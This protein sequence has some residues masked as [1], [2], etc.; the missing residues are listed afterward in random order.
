MNLNHFAEFELENTSLFRGVEPETIQDL[1][2]AALAE[3]EL[4]HYVK[5]Y[6]KK[7]QSNEFLSSEKSRVDGVDDIFEQLLG[8]P[9]RAGSE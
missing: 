6:R 7:V 1:V 4:D 9:A 8:K 2:Q 3:S 5:E